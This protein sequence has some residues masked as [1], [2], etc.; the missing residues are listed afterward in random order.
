[1]PVPGFDVPENYYQPDN[2]EPEMAMTINLDIPTDA[3]VRARRNVIRTILGELV[4]HNLN[5]E[6]ATQ[7]MEH[8]MASDV[9]P[10]K[11]FNGGDIPPV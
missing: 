4:S 5:I 1:M 9:E 11:E 8:L 6:Q 10:L 7:A 2:E 3:M